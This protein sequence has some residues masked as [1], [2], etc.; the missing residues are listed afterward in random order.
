MMRPTLS[1]V[2]NGSGRRTKHGIVKFGSVV[3][4]THFDPALVVSPDSYTAKVPVIVNTKKIPAD[5]RVILKWHSI[6]P[7]KQQGKRVKT[8][9]DEVGKNEKARFKHAKQ[10]D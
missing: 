6:T 8:W 3:S 4:T 7:P 9:V 5:E 1:G 2:S 10:A